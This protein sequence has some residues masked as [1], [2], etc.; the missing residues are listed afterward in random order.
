[1]ARANP[2]KLGGVSLVVA[3]TVVS[4]MVCFLYP[5][6][7]RDGDRTGLTILLTGLAIFSIGLWDDFRP[8]GFRRRLILQA[9]VAALVCFRGVRIEVLNS[10]LTEAGMHLG[11][12][13]G[14][15]TLLW[16]VLFMA[17]F[18]SINSVNGLAGCLG[19]VSMGLLAYGAAAVGTAFSGLCAIG[20]A[21]ALI[22]FLVYN[23]PP[24]KIQLGSSGAGLLGFLVGNLS[25]AHP[26]RGQQS[27]MIAMLII[28]VLGAC[29]ATWR[30]SV[31]LLSGKP[32]SPKLVVRPISRLSS[33]Q[34]RVRR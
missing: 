32:S 31:S 5:A 34:A 20:M 4:L 12:W 23:L 26:D 28:A 2:S 21:G 22:G 17:L 9:L 30:A 33:P 24:A 15:V 6:A 1:M 7:W 27:A 25:I 18:Q 11:G 19:L 3:F 10:P 29:F 16:L 8:L 14:V 13:S